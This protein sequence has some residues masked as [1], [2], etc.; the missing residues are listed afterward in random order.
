MLVNPA[1]DVTETL[2]D[3]ASITEYAH[4]P[5][6]AVPQ[7][8]LFRRLAV[9]QG[10]DPRALS[11]LYADSLSGL[12]PALVVVPTHDPLADH[13]RRYAERLHEAGTP[14]R[15]TEY[16]GSG[17]AFLSV[18][19]VDPQAEAARTEILDYLRTALGT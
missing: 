16:A 10:T 14:A 8:Q 2:F 12:A 4:T 5:F 19:G 18:P 11:P 3:H 6:L 9:P 1:V 7:L 15:L 13:G 17:H